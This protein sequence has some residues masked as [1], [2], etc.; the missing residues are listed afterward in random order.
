[1]AVGECTWYYDPFGA[2]TINAKLYGRGE[3][4]KKSGLSVIAIATSKMKALNINLKGALILVFSA[5]ESSSCLGAKRMIDRGDLFG[6]GV[7]LVSTPSSL[8][9][10]IA[11]KG[12]LWPHT[13]AFSAPRHTFGDNCENAILRLMNFWIKSTKRGLQITTIPFCVRRPQMLA[14]SMVE[15]A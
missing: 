4:D 1:M 6:A 8:N 7:L 2:N 10:L 14:L 3:A 13:R 11:E 15:L 12:A 5:G 9:L